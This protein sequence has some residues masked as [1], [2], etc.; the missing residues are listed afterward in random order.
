MDILQFIGFISGSG[1]LIA[2]F[3]YLAKRFIDKSLDAAVERYKLNL[4][5]DLELYKH[6]LTQE[7]ER[8]RF[9]LNKISLEHQSKY[10]ALYQERGNI[11]KE[12]YSKI[13]VVETEL[14]NLTTVMQGPDWKKTENNFALKELIIQFEKSFEVNRLFFSKEI[15]DNIESLI[16]RMKTINHKMYSAKLRAE[17]NEYL[18]VHNHVLSVEARLEPKDTW[19][20][21]EAEASTEIKSLRREL[22]R[23][24]AKLIGVE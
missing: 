13:L 4:Q 20:S 18:E 6:N 14:L 10:N 15:C 8:L 11:I 7:G 21:L 24:F 1:L 19:F 22:E 2:G 17:T 12:T 5:Q 3:T 16:E 23:E 9:E